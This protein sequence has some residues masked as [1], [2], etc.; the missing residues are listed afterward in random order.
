M[1]R[2]LSIAVLFAGLVPSAAIADADGIHV[3]YD[4]ADDTTLTVVFRQDPYEAVV[5]LPDG[6]VM[7]LP[8][9]AS[10]SGF[11]YTNGRYG[12]RGKGNEAMWEIGRMVPIDCVARAG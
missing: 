7:T 3:V 1:M 10:G 9:A 2:A 11:Y 12:L 5:D 6:S 4:C 8:G